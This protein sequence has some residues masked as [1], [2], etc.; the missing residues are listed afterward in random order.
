MA[1]AQLED[2][3]HMMYR[4]IAL[5]AAL[6]LALGVGCSAKAESGG[7]VSESTSSTANAG[8]TAGCPAALDFTEK[9][10]DG[11]DVNLCSYKGDV[12]LIVNVA[13]KCGFT[14]Q[15]KGLEELNKKYRER[16]LRILGFPSNDFGGQEPGSESE[17]KQFCSSTFG[18]SFD[19]FSKVTVKGDSK[20]DLYRYLT[21]GGGNPAIAGDVKWNFQKYLIDRN[22]NLVAVFPSNVEP[23]SP[24]LTGAIEKLL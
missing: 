3:D 20:V 10:I 23:T 15:Y 1:T 18:V 9:S 13:S 5:A 4:T 17:I 11:K 14:P 12:V 22:G 21:A 7:A 8:G 16:G 24:E 19:M 2:N 6:G